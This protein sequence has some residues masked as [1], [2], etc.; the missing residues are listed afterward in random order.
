MS[1]PELRETGAAERGQEGER[2]IASGEAAA[3]EWRRQLAEAR[4]LAGEAADKGWSVDHR[5]AAIRNALFIWKKMLDILVVMQAEGYITPSEDGTGF[6]CVLDHF[7]PG[8]INAGEPYKIPVEER[9]IRA[10][11]AR[12]ETLLAELDAQIELRK[13]QIELRKTNGGSRYNFVP[14]DAAISFGAAATFWALIVGMAT[15]TTHSLPYSLAAILGLAVIPLAV[16][17]GIRRRA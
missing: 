15:L 8:W 13:T 14:R 17:G 5:A 1:K 9:S 10:E 12:G 7:M 16:S 11:I 4:E 2:A 3:S 6:F